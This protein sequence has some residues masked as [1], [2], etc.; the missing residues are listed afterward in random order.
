M[1]PRAHPGWSA[2]SGA[3]A[4][5]SELRRELSRRQEVEG[6]VA[7]PP[8]QLGAA[9]ADAREWSSHFDLIR[10]S[11]RVLLR[12]VGGARRPLS[13]RRFRAFVQEELRLE[14]F[15]IGQVPS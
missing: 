4:A 12:E 14:A 5:T 3:V 11:E 8:G 2:L 9:D 6:T 10:D 13:Y 7:L 1:A 15:G